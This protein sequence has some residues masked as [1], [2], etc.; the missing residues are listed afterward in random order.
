[1][2]QTETFTF[3]VQGYDRS[4]S[5]DNWETIEPAHIRIWKSAVS[6]LRERRLIAN[7]TTFEVTMDW[8]PV[9]RR[10]ERHHQAM[11][12]L[13]KGGHHQLAQRIFKARFPRRASKI[14]VHVRSLG[15]KSTNLLQSVAV[16]AIHDIFLIMNIAAPGCCN[17]Y[18]GRLLGKDR[19]DDISLSSDL[20]ELYLVRDQW[21]RS[22][23][24]NLDQVIVWY[25]Q[26][27]RGATQL[28]NSST[29][30][31]LFALLHLAQLFDVDA[32]AVIWLFYALES[33]LETRPG[34]NFSAIVRR[35]SLL[36]EADSKQATTI[37]SELRTL[38]DIRSAMV[39]GGL[40]VVHPMRHEVLDKRVNNAV[41]RL[42]RATDFG[43][44]ATIAAIQKM[45][46]NGW[47]NL[48]FD[49]VI[50]GR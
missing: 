24:L 16:S 6:R 25:D 18:R 22:R 45:A 48:R 49:E 30:R 27:R 47:C 41:G 23:V 12:Y 33:L 4:F 17:F 10:S 14:P 38:Y 3:S 8:T 1:M 26:V 28:P 39:H 19:E 11:R 44:S 13:N 2:E 37:K 5:D 31:A 21:P 46:E 32:V 29:E 42:M 36:L 40:E 15:K 43:S 9:L 34:E 50:A 7:G 35:L 20:F